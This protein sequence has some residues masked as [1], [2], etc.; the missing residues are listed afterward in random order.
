MENTYTHSHDRTQATNAHLYE[1]AFPAPIYNCGMQIPKMLSEIMEATGW[2]Q[3][4][5]AN[6]LGT[7][8]PT[9]SR[10]MHGADPRGK[11]R[12]DIRALAEEVLQ[13]GVRAAPVIRGHYVPLISWVSAGAPKT[14]DAVEEI[15]SAPRI[16]APDL[17]PKGEWI[18]L[19]VDGDSMD[20]ISPPDS[21]IFVN[22]KDRRLVANA[23]YVITNP[24]DGA[25]TYK[26]WRPNPNRWEP[27]SVNPE[28]E[29]LFV[30]GDQ[31]KVI[32]RVRKS[33]LSM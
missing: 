17:D 27:V 18:A 25:A 23:C 13:A 10:W 32:G 19:R 3:G 11:H 5:L 1:A 31:P 33:V 16:Y 20:R 28:H 26:R 12:D 30:D 2:K 14:P 24:D 4:E 7:T 15:E 29:P 21:I 8:Q 6:R 9:L 22:M